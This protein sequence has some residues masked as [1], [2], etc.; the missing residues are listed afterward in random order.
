MGLVDSLLMVLEKKRG[1]YLPT[2]FITNYI[3]I[4]LR[5]PFKFL[6]GLTE[7]I[8]MRV[9]LSNG[10]LPL[11]FSLNP[12]NND[13]ISTSIQYHIDVSFFAIRVRK[14]HESGQMIMS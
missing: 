11:Y 12:A 4:P 1:F 9:H 5:N 2:P 13:R 14:S 3:P 10:L 7:H 8:P 6:Q